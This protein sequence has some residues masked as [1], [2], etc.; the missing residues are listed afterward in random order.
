[1]VSGDG[2]GSRPGGAVEGDL[3]G[4]ACAWRDSGLAEATRIL[5]GAMATWATVSL[6]SLAQ[7]VG[8]GPHAEAFLR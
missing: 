8:L 5:F 2:H 4:S 7:L 1:M 6:V 3:G